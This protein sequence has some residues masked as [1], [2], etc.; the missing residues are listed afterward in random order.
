M[1]DTL[2]THSIVNGSSSAIV[3]YD[4]TVGDGG[5]GTR[6]VARAEPRAAH[7]ACSPLAA[8]RYSASAVTT[9]APFGAQVRKRDRVA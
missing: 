1:C 3:L 7:T 6:V 5:L 4:M 9:V 2:Y 8:R